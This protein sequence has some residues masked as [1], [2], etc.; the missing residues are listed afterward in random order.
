MLRDAGCSHAIL[1]HSERRHGLGETDAD[2]RAKTEAAWRAGLL[3]IV[4]VGEKPAERAAG[5]AIQIVAARPARSPPRGAPPARPVLAYR[6]V[7]ALRPALSPAFA[8]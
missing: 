1:G 3:A 8:P 5:R 4:C 7:W 6:P 2:V